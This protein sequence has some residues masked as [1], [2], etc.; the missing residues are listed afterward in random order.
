M[1]EYGRA[2]PFED[3]GDSDLHV[4]SL[5][6]GGTKG[7]A[8]D[9][10]IARIV[11]VGNQ[12]GFR[13]AGSPNR[14]TVRLSVLYTS[15]TEIDWP[16]TLDAQTG[17]MTY[18]GDNRKPGHELHQTPRGGNQLLRDVFSA[19]HGSE[20]DRLRVPP[21]LL[22]EKSAPGRAV[23]FRGLLAP[24]AATMTSDDELAAIWRSKDGLRF[25]NYRARFT[26]LD[27][28]T[29]P[30]QW[31]SAILADQSVTS[32]ACP[33]AWRD[34]VQG[35]AYTPLVAP[36]TAVVRTKAQ[37]MPTDMTGHD[38]LAAIHR[39]FD[40]RSTD[41]E[42]CAVAL[43]RLI[44]PSTGRCDVTQ[45]SRDG[46]R[47]AVGEYLLGP[48]DDRVMIDFALEAKCYGP[49][50]SVGVKDVSR[51]ISRI[52]YRNFG[53]FVTLSH[54]GQQVYDEVRSDGHPIAMICG[55]DIVEVLKEHGYGDVTSVNAWLAN[56]FPPRG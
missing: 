2:I 45:P 12:G 23:R 39:H 51:L 42:S 1:T 4:D 52:R 17:V 18:Y 3:L 54:F 24:G 9:D 56:M 27:V 25:Q 32:S 8:G 44:A 16:D 7:T 15:G 20:Q 49:N 36:S 35:R 40:G 11:P 38:I 30:R 50:T 34:W 28:A 37:Q 6:L 26:V 19:A 43:W 21:F 53:V 29:V 41:F 47:D 48:I 55:R 22:F 13:H 33:P 14:G 10:P 46:G 5:Y 31:L